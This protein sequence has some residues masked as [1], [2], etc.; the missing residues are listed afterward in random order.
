MGIPVSDEL[1]I[2]RGKY[3]KEQ[4]NP[5]IKCGFSKGWVRGFKNRYNIIQRKAGSKIVRK[6]D[7]DMVVLTDFVKLINE[8][9]NSGDYFAI[10]NI[11]ETGL[12]YDP[13]INFTLDV[14]GTARV[15][16]KT[17][18]EKNRELQSC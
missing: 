14:K 18:E 4:M 13:T 17:T 6:N 8:K 15:E 10:I 12:Y 2:C 3:L 16:I 9:I 1:I 11:D 5:N 7:C